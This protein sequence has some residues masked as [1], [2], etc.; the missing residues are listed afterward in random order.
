MKSAVQRLM[1]FGRYCNEM[2]AW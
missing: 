1:L 2:F